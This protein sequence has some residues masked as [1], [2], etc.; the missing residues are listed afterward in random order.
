[1]DGGLLRWIIVLLLVLCGMFGAAWLSLSKVDLA[2]WAARRA[3]ASLGREVA[4]DSLR[5]EP[6]R[7]LGVTLHGL[8]VANLPGG[9][10]PDMV[11]LRMARAEIDLFSLLSGSPVLRQAGV[12]GL[13]LLLEHGP[14]GAANWQRPGAASAARGRASPRPSDLPAILTAAFSDAAVDFRTSSGALLRIRLAGA[15]L[16]L[17]P[18][19]PGSLSARGSYNGISAQVTGSLLPPGT[20]HQSG[21]PFAAR[22]TLRC[23]NTLLRFAGSIADPLGFDG[24]DGAVSLDAPSLDTLLRIAGLD[25][26]GAPALRLAGHLRH[27]GQLWSLDGATGKVGD[28]AIE[29]A[30]LALEEGA[31]GQPDSIAAKLLFGHLDLDALLGRPAVPQ[32]GR[33][34]RDADVAL[35]VDQAPDT[36]LQARLAASRLSYGAVEATDAHLHASLTPGR[37]AVEGFGLHDLGGRISGQGEVVAEGGSAG[38]I[39]AM[40]EVAGLD[41]EALRHALQAG[42]LPFSGRLDG[43]FAITAQGETL[44]AAAQGAHAAAVVSMSG[45]WIDRRAIEIAS[46]DL[47]SVFRRAEGRTA[48]RCLLGVMDLRA[49]IATISPL[50]LRADTGTIA[51]HGRLDLNRRTV[52]MTVGSES[53]T[54]GALALDIPVR[55]NGPIAD[56]SIRPAAW[57]AEGR[58][59][60][61][62]SDIVERLPQGLRPMARGNPCLAPG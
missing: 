33:Q 23:G 37:V 19:A 22:L 52:D 31:R 42:R 35:A 13:R 59:S 38:R 5:L 56:P 39:Q 61:H 10:E 44:N 36:L 7:W 48:L 20:S 50:R 47:R 26:E 51:G 55:I 40:A 14:D 54:T 45:G 28:T 17:P 46:T 30:S 16:A 3:S 8:R 41:S 12:H 58:A 11:T 18:G 49:G 29:G 1:M 27:T 57:S 4:L 21:A 60:L 2:S 25:E 15:Q 62:A 53:N 6:G 9:S 43:R 24:L 34:A 32:R